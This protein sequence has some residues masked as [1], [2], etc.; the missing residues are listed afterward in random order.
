MHAFKEFD[1]VRHK[2]Y[3]WEGII[4]AIT[5]QRKIRVKLFK[6]GYEWVY[7]SEIELCSAQ[8]EKVNPKT[9]IRFFG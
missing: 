4:D 7:P 6:G 5:P 2:Y 3:K 9:D 1:K 8:Q